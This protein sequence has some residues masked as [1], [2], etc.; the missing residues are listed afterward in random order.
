MNETFS[1]APGGFVDSY[2]PHG[3]HDIFGVWVD[4]FSGGWLKINNGGLWV[5]PYTRGW[6]AT[7]FPSASSITVRSYD[8]A[9][10]TQI[11]GAT[12]QA[13]QITIWDEPQG[14][15]E[16]IDFFDAQTIPLM[17]FQANTVGAA[18]VVIIPAPTVGRIR[19]YDVT[20][21]YV[22]SSLDIFEDV[23]VN[24]LPITANIMTTT[25]LSPASPTSRIIITPPGGDLPIGSN[26][27]M[28]C[29]TMDGSVSTIHVSV[30]VRYAI[31]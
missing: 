13:A 30:L 8:F 3:F 20:F 25:T 16:G 4:N 21:N 9:N 29:F 18:V 11:T 5:P 17:T 2:Q 24:L 26:L 7:I 12:G 27:R 22:A 31:I 1:V 10:G 15:T 6:R 14:D 23:G 28:T 19:V